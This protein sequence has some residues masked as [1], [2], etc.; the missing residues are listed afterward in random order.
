[1]NFTDLEP[2]RV[3]LCYWGY[4][5]GRPGMRVTTHEHDFWQAN[6]SLSGRCLMKTDEGDFDLRGKNLIFI[7]P[8]VRHSLSYPEPYL[9]YSCKFHAELSGL[10]RVIFLDGNDFTC[11]VI[12]AAKVILETTFPKRFFGLPNG[13]II[14][15]QDRY[16]VLMEHF[17]TG[18]LDSLQT[19]RQESSGILRRLYQEQEKLGRPFFS[20]EEAAGAC[21]YSR[22]HFSLLIRQQTGLSARDF[23]NRV[24]LESARRYL[25]YSDRSLGEIAAA[26]GFSSQFHFT[27]FFKRMTGIPPLRYRKEK[28]GKN[29]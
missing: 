1:M 16:Q 20:V 26:L 21:G 5:E 6:F 9:C 15:P 27:D 23:L 24:R 18:L 28:S 25:S 12:R 7:A 10:S 17:L 11:G 13:T 14:L 3:R 19:D 8:G 2:A 4:A 29:G 22:N